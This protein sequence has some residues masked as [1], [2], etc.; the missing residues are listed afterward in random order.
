MHADEIR[1]ELRLRTLE[2]RVWRATALGTA[3]VASLAGCIAVSARREGT[4]RAS[5]IEL[6]DSAGRVRVV[7]AAELGTPDLSGIEIRGTDGGS[8][9]VILAGQYPVT[10]GTAI[11]MAKIDLEVDEQGADGYSLARMMAADSTSEVSVTYDDTRSIC[12]LASPEETSLALGSFRDTV[13]EV[14]GV[15]TFGL[16]ALPAITLSDGT[17]TTEILVRDSEGVVLFKAP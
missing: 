9:I 5:R 8:S 15:T 6:V 11:A 1:V 13:D 17:E 2:R 10:D 16:E 4:V 14:H 3:L 12:L 7:V